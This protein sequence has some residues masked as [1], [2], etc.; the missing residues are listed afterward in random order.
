MCVCWAWLCVDYFVRH[1]FAL[2]QAPEGQRWAVREHLRL[3]IP[4]YCGHS[5]CPPHVATLVNDKAA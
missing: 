4:R 5:D 2:E 3:E 1:G